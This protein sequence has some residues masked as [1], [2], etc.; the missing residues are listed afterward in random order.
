MIYHFLVDG[1]VANEE[2]VEE[3]PNLVVLEEVG[4]PVQLTA[5]FAIPKNIS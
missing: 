5:V 1:G 3:Y 4:V 2:R